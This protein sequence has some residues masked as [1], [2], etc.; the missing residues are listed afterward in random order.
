MDVART[1]S[2]VAALL[3]SETIV[4]WPDTPVSDVAAVLDTSGASGIPVV[5]WS[6]YLV[7]VVSRLDIVRVRASDNLSVDWSRLCARHVMSQDWLTVAIDTPLEDAARLVESH[8]VGR[9]VVVENDGES[10]IGVVSAIDLAGT[11]AGR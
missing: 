10:P 7:G 2:T 4:V 1:D 5:D 11:I 3:S 6:G 9:I 8:N